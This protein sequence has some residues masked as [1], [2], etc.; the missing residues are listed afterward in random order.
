MAIGIPTGKE[1]LAGS[2]SGGFLGPGNSINTCRSPAAMSTNLPFKCTSL[3]APLG[4][5]SYHNTLRAKPACTLFNKL[6]I[7]DGG[8][9]Y[10]YFVSTCL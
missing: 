9:I 5:N 10:A 6:G 3:I 1:N 2:K 4:V 8:S 7:K